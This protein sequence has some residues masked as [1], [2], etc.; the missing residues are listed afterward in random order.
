[1]TS[2]Q[3]RQ[4]IIELTGID[5]KFNQ[6]QIRRDLNK[7]EWNAVIKLEDKK[8]QQTVLEKM[9]FFKWYADEN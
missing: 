1:V 3:I 9:R 7:P 8:D 4:K 5:L 6:P 2:N